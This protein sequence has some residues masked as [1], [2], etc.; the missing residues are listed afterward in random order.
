MPAQVTK[1]SSKFTSDKLAPRCTIEDKIDV[2]EDWMNGWLLN[3]ASAL[4]DQKY[5]FRSEASF[6]V[7]MIA[8]AYFETIESYHVGR[9]SHNQSKAFFRRGF[10]RVFVNL[11]ATLKASGFANEDQLAEEIADELYTHLRCGLFHEGGTRH[12]ILVFENTHPLSMMVETTTNN[13]GSIVIDP[14]RF[15]AEVRNHVVIYTSQLRDSTQVNL[16]QN[17]ESFFDQRIS[18]SNTTVLPPLSVL[19]KT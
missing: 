1:I 19:Q 6:V 14:A 8:T 18:S 11:P 2:F 7:L 15:L 5:N 3:H 12:K 16:R 9:S 10:L 4:L 17:F 13:V